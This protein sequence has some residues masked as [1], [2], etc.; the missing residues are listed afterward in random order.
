MYHSKIHDMVKGKLTKTRLGPTQQN[1]CKHFRDQIKKG[2]IKAG[3][4]K[5]K[6]KK[7]GQL[8]VRGQEERSVESQRS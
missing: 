5:V 7:A 2:Y 4:F 3:E 6:V 1:L 8:K